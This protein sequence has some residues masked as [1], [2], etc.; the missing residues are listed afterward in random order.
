MFLLGLATLTGALAALNE[1]AINTVSQNPPADTF[2]NP[3]STYT[4]NGSTTVTEPMPYTPAGGLGTNGST[5]VYHPL[6]DFDYESMALALY[7]EYIELDLF[8]YGL[9]RFSQQDFFDAG[10]TPGDIDLLRFMGQQEIGHATLITNILGA[11]APLP[12]NYTYPNFTSV[13]DYLNF[14]QE[15]TRIGESGVYGF[16]NHLDS[17]ATAQLLLQS[18][19]TEARQQMVFRQFTGLSP[20]GGVWFEPGF[21][22]SQAWAWLS[23]YITSCPPRNLGARRLAWQNF[24]HLNVTNAPSV[25]PPQNTSDVFPAGITPA[26]NRTTPLSPAGRNVTFTY[27]AP[28][29]A[30]GPNGQYTTATSAGAPAYVAWQSQLNITYSVFYPTSNN[31][32]WTL[33]PNGTIWPSYYNETPYAAGVHA[34]AGTNDPASQGA[35]NGTIILSLVDA[36]TPA[37]GLTAFNI[38]YINSHIV[39]GPALYTVS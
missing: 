28:G 6:S 18:I 23:Q 4:A 24:P 15:L 1:T 30:T 22:Q 27:E 38:S 39:A 37:L 5:P 31:S 11:N 19:S 29:L 14:N 20:F 7:Q 10:F 17:R 36:A 25:V 12:C 26:Q 34:L 13:K 33:Q 35:I 21:T 8:N 3:G 16:I 2:G 32:G 9:V